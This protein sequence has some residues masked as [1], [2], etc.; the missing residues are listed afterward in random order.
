MTSA[1]PIAPPKSF[2]YGLTVP[3]HEID[4]AGIMFYGHLFRHAHDAYEGFMASIGFPLD[5]VIREGE[6]LLPLVHAQADYR[7]PLRHAERVAV[8]LCVE[9]VGRTSFTLGYRF[10]DQEGRVRAEA[11]TVHV[12]LDAKLRSSAPL[13]DALGKALA[14]WLCGA[15]G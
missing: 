10:E 7:F 9:E 13:P 15:E 4:A 1:L 6:S 8:R 3:F 12:H 5:R 2:S 11:R 14:D